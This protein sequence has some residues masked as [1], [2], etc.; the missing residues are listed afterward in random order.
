MRMKYKE[1]FR[2]FIRRNAVMFVTFC[3]G[4]AIAIALMFVPDIFNPANNLLVGINDRIFPILSIATLGVAIILF[5][6]ENR[7]E[8]EV[9]LPKR[10]TVNLMSPSGNGRKSLA[11][12]RRL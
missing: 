9:N 12:R 3:C 7:Q 6:S 5:L 11:L 8:W 4:I 2:F 1:L 10:L